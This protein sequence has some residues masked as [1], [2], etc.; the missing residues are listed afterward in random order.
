MTLI[1]VKL[2]QRVELIKNDRDAHTGEKT[3]KGTRGTI[4]GVPAWRHD[5]VD[6]VFDGDK[7]HKCIFITDLKL[8]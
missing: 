6:V 3:L 5:I 1:E 4:T 7:F 2:E 8:I